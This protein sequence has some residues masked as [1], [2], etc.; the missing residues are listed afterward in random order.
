MMLIALAGPFAQRR[1]APK[2]DWIWFGPCYRDILHC[3][4]FDTLGNHP[5]HF[6]LAV[7]DLLRTVSVITA[8]PWDQRFFDPVILPGRKPLVTLRD[9]ALHCGRC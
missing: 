5:R 6:G 8:V 4:P 2:S 3:Q 7:R 9:A 1:F